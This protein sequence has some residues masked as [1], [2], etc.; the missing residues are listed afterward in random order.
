MSDVNDWNQQVITEFR[1][2]GGK[3][4]SFE[5]ATVVLLHHRG[6]K[7]GTERINPLAA[8]PL[9]RGWAVFASK[10]GAPT[11][12]DWYYNLMADPH[13]TIEVGTDVVEVDAR[14]VDGEQR[15]RIWARQKELMPGF[16]DYETK[17]AGARRI[18]VIILEPTD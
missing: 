17:L 7:S 10:A 18:P 16:A 2:N 11:N 6:R 9:E 8:Q 5:G 3:V 13:T 1:A 14:E 4:A 12:P 15:D